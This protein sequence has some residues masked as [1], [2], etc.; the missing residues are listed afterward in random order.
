MLTHSYIHEAK[1]LRLKLDV[2][3][4]H[5]ASQQSAAL[6]LWFDHTMK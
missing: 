3:G 6:V 5:F 4:H 2:L 1:R